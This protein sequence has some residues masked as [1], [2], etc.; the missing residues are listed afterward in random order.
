LI[1]QSWELQES[2]TVSSAQASSGY[3][4][5]GAGHSIDEAEISDYWNAMGCRRKSEVFESV[6]AELTS[7]LSLSPN[8]KP[9]A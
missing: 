1:L 9:H 4:P 6:K 3:F 2:R 5:K 8:S 7:L